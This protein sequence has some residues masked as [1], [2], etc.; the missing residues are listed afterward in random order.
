MQ[1]RELS[2]PDSY[3]ITPKQF[4]DSRGVFLEWYRFDRLEETIGHRLEIAQAN[5]SVSKRG[6]VRGIHFAD[7][8]PSQAKYVTAVRGAVLDYIID[9]RVGSPTFGQWDSVLLDDT[10]RRAVYIAEGLGH[11]FVALTDDATVSYLVTAP[12]NPGREHG[13]NPLD[14]DIGLVFPP[15]AGE[16]LLSPKDTDAPGLAESAASGLLPTWADAKAFYAALNE[17]K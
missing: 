7:I 9:I 8:P 10:D 12:F 3:E 4:G 16:L 6:S 1:I 14:A 5:T 13:I 15:E 2:I 17:G 11:C